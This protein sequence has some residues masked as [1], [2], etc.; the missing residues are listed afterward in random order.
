MIDDLQS[1]NYILDRTDESFSRTILDLIVMDRL[2]N[3]QDKDAYHRLLLCAE[4]AV[5]IKV[6]DEFG[7]WDYC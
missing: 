7:E 4:V 1:N 3:L 6:V 5:S 2:N